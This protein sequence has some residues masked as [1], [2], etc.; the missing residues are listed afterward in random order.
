MAL[1]GVVITSIHDD[2][3]VARRE[4][5]AQIAFYV[6]PK[7]YG[8]VMEASGF[9]SEAA[10]IQSAFRAQ[11]HDGMVAAV[12]D[13]MLDEMA[14]HGTVDEVRQRVAALEKRYDHA[15]LYSPSFQMAPERVR[16]NTSAI[17][18]AFAR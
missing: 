12:S 2:P 10:A 15:A 6:A 14:A 5:A 11:D 9:G 8:P 17:I 13:G 3:G 16:E 7:A 1:K 4:A 18:E